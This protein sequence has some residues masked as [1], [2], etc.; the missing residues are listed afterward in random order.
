MIIVCLF[1]TATPEQRNVDE[2]VWRR[3]WERRKMM[4]DCRMRTF[5]FLTL[6]LTTA[7]NLLSADKIDP[8]KQSYSNRHSF[9]K[10]TKDGVEL[11]IEELLIPNKSNQNGG[12]VHLSER[13]YSCS[14]ICVLS[15]LQIVGTKNSQLVSRSDRIGEE[16][17]QVSNTTLQI[18]CTAIVPT[19]E[20][21]YAKNSE[22][23]LDSVTVW[24]DSPESLVISLNSH[25]I[26]SSITF[27][28][29]T[30]HS[31]IVSLVRNEENS[32]SVTL[33]STSMTDLILGSSEPLVASSSTFS[34][35]IVWSSFTNISMSATSQELPPPKTHQTNRMIGCET[36]G[37]CCVHDG[38]ITRSIN[39]A[40]SFVFSNNTFTHTDRSNA[41][42]TYTGEQTARIVP[43]PNEVL[44]DKCHFKNCFTTTVGGGAICSESIGQIFTVASSSFLSCYTLEARFSGGGMYISHTIASITDT[45]FESCNALYGGACASRQYEYPFS[46]CRNNSTSGTA[47]YEPA[48]D[49]DTSTSTIITTGNR[50]EDNLAKVRTCCLV[51]VMTGEISNNLF[52]D[53]THLKPELNHATLEVYLQAPKSLLMYGNTFEGGNFI[54]ASCNGTI[55]NDILFFHYTSL[56]LEFHMTC[57]NNQLY[58]PSSSRSND[59]ITS[60]DTSNIVYA[61]SATQTYSAT[62]SSPSPFVQFGRPASLVISSH[63]FDLSAKPVSFGGF[64]GHSKVILDS[65]KITLNST[66]LTSDFIS[67]STAS[68][69]IRNIALSSLHVDSFSFIRMTGESSLVVSSSNFSNF[70]QTSGSGGSFVVMDGSAAQHTSLS[71]CRFDSL[72]STGNGGVILATLT[73]D[74]TLTVEDCIFTSCSSG[75]NGGAMSVSCA[76]GVPSSSFVVKSTFASCTCGSGQ[77][78]QWVFVEGSSFLTLLERENWLSIV[79]SL[80]TPTDDNLLW[81][82]DESELEG[83]KYRSMT[84][85]YYLLPFR[86]VTIHSSSEG[87]DED[88]CGRLEWECKSLEVGASHLSGAGSHKLIVAT[89]TTLTTPLSFSTNAIEIC[90]TETTASITTGSAG[91]LA[92]S[93]FTLTLTSISFDG[94]SVERSSSLLE[95]TGSGW[96][97][98]SGCSFSSF[99]KVG[100]GSIFSSSLNSGNSLTF[101]DTTFSSCSSSGRG[102]ALAVTMNGGSF[103]MDAPITFVS[104]TSTENEGDGISVISADLVAFISSSL[105]SLKPAAQTSPY[106]SLEKKKWFGVDT[107]TSS[108]GSLLFYWYPHTSTEESTHI[109]ADGEDHA[110][111][112]RESLPCSSFN[113]TLSHPNANDKFVVDSAMTLKEGLTI[114]AD[115]ILTSSTS[116]QTITT[117]SAAS[118]TIGLKSLTL[119]DLSLTSSSRTS[120]FLSLS[121]FGSLILTSCSFLSFSNTMSD[122]SVLSAVLGSATKLEIS[123]CSF[124]KC[125]SA[126]NGGVIA[127]DLCDL[128]TPSNLVLSSLSFGEAE[129]D[130]ANLCGAGKLGQNIYVVSLPTQRSTVKTI[131]GSVLPLKPANDASFFSSSEMNRLEF[132]E[133]S[134]GVVSGIGSLLFVVFSYDGGDLTVD[135]SSSITHSLCGHRFL[136]CSS[137]SGG[138]SFVKKAG[139]TDGRL[140]VRGGVSLHATITTTA[141]TVTITSTSEVE[142]I[143]VESGNYF[144]I[145]GG[146]LTVSSLAFVNTSE[147]FDDSLFVLSGVGSLS[148]SGCSFTGFSSSVKGSVICGDVG[149]GLEVT[150]C[151]FVSCS[152]T[153]NEGDW[154]SITSADLVKFLSSS[155]ASLKPAAQTSPYSSLEKKKWFG[156]DTLTSSEGS[157]LFYWY[158]H[159]ST[160]E[161]THIHADGEDHALCG[162]ESLPCSSFNKTLSHPNA[163]DKFV[164]DSAMTLKEGLTITADTILTSSTSKQTITTTSSASLTIVQNSL[165]LLDLSFIGPSRPSSFISLSSASSVLVVNDCSFSSFT[166]PIAL[167]DFAAGSLS[168]TSTKFHQIARSDGNGSVLEVEMVEGMELEIDH[169]ELSDVTTQNGV[170]NGFFVSFTTISDEMKIPAFSLRNLKYS[171]SS[172]SNSNGAFVWIEGNHLDEWIAYDD[173]RF[174]GSFETGVL[175]EWL[176]SVDH[177]TSLNASLL[178][179]LIAGSGAIGVASDGLDL[180]KCGHNSVW[181]RTLEHSLTRASS[182]LTTTLH[183]MREVSVV[184]SVEMGGVTVKGLPVM[185]SI[186]LSSSGCLREETGD[187]VQFESVT[188][189]LKEG[190]RCSAAL[191]VLFGHMNLWMV[192]MSVL[193]DQT[194]PLFKS[195]DSILTL[196]TITLS[197]S[198]NVGTLMDCEKGTVSV[199]SLIIATISFSSTPIR[200]SHLDSANLIQLQVSNTSDE[201]FIQCRNI[202]TLNLQLCSFEGPKQASNNDEQ[203]SL[204]EWTTGLI[205]ISDSTVSVDQSRFTH[206]SQGALFLS[207][208][209]TTIHSSIFSNNIVGSSEFPSARKNI[210]CEGGE[211]VVDSL[212]GGDGSKDLPSAWISLDSECVFSSPVIEPSAVFFVPTLTSTESPA[213]FSKASQQYTLT[214]TGSLLM[215]CN[216]GLEVFSLDEK[217]VETGSIPIPLSASNT[218]NW[219]ESSF[220]FQLSSS[221]LSSLDS[222]MEWRCRIVFGDGFATDSTLMKRSAS[223]ERKAQF[224]SVRKWLIPVI[225]ASSVLLLLF[226]IILIIV[227]VRR[228]NKQKSESEQVNAKTEMDEQIPIEKFDDGESFAPTLV[229]TTAN[230]QKV[231]PNEFDEGGRLAPDTLQHGRERG[232]R[233]ENEGKFEAVN[234]SDVS[235][236]VVV[237]WKDTLYRRLHSGENRMIGAERATITQQLVRGLLNLAQKDASSL[238]LRNVSPHWIVFDWTNQMYLQTG[239]VKKGESVLGSVTGNTKEDSAGV[240]GQR[241]IAPELMDS[242]SNKKHD[243]GA[244]FS[245]GL[246]LWELETGCVP[247]GELDAANAHRQLGCGGQLSMTKIS[248]PKLVSLIEKCLDLDPTRRPTLAEVSKELGEDGLF[249]S[250]TIQPDDPLGCDF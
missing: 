44:F 38:T 34:T 182:V 228:R 212:N 164:V 225:I 140:L 163:N 1:G 40:G 106:S 72:S 179:Y 191:V 190:G 143:S 93:A 105:A 85:L 4:R 210:R 218:M 183:V 189:V 224:A 229:N 152:S 227:L 92:V 208:T 87:R 3:V 52:R 29:R 11:T 17:F 9:V 148:L 154:I 89:S 135:E 27:K 157:L 86:H 158:P 192:K 240:E 242:E 150:E 115:T 119:L 124:E 137:L 104:C 215:D 141:K 214:L 120:P 165:T 112:G 110:L 177:A 245:L 80:T 66:A 175:F 142:T 30:S 2:A 35:Q 170:A 213:S 239:E 199:N 96:I 7:T 203:E 145:C 243:H 230:L 15:P 207:N 41:P 21:I 185:S 186:V 49:T 156:V 79:S 223:D 64:S 60:S 58:F 160:E 162:R 71:S 56:K 233:V 174:T 12:Y 23:T 102:G 168:L 151:L 100:D 76:V 70:A 166:L 39:M 219:T 173:S 188:V 220:S 180:A 211:V 51:E 53:N 248:S 47:T 68:H 234:C 50:F 73:P 167:I 13:S 232:K 237:N 20:A 117:T 54:Y 37:V 59:T 197:S 249:S 125:K 6:F 130:Y 99:L 244:V 195:V 109:H 24:K 61:G 98:V 42:I 81:G 48:F 108:E 67:L 25:I 153:E 57:T 78:G 94:Q 46:F 128:T 5:T 235:E 147:S 247:F 82:T 55:K 107:L 33:S 136:P 246:I 200:L 111:C 26:L 202:T 65:I 138:Y 172:S 62:A 238:G 187:T 101:D 131:F 103:S 159:T 161:S 155:L 32:G 216:L 206:L 178:F 31:T 193:A 132:G 217:K 90:P 198:H 19:K 201:I 91:R 241:W 226:F 83:S 95:I 184:N 97:V 196:H 75:G 8:S 194:T 122:G 250:R 18:E 84:L 205:S 14:S 133:E 16:M 123:E 222:K 134:S 36:D 221:A 127:V 146:S 77:K 69:I 149:G 114:T 113:K 116:K 169:V 231:N 204:C 176:W 74:S 126:G 121:S 171:N 209:T 236:K 118:V 43:T 45:K 88:G 63:S 10:R 129:T 144:W 139:E 28:H 22:I 181:C